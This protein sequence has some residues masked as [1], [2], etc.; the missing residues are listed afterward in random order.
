MTAPKEKLVPLP[1]LTEARNQNRALKAKIS[2]MTVRET[3]V[4]ALLQQLGFSISAACR[5]NQPSSATKTPLRHC[6]VERLRDGPVPPRRA[7][8]YAG[9]KVVRGLL[10]PLRGLGP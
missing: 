2:E 4:Q 9:T 10:L 6:S 3:A 7:G 5:L 8:S 1:A